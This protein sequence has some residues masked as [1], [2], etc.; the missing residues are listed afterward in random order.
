MAPAAASN[1]GLEAQLLQQQQQ[2]QLLQQQLWQQQQ[3]QQQH[4][5]QQQQSIQS[6]AQFASSSSPLLLDPF[7]MAQLGL[8]GA[9]GLGGG[10]TLQD[11]LLLATLQQMEEIQQLALM[12]SQASRQSGLQQ[13]AAGLYGGLVDGQLLGL[14]PGANH[15]S[16]LGA[17]P[18]DVLFNVGKPPSRSDTNGRLGSK[19]T[20][21][22]KPAS[23]RS[24]SHHPAPD[25]R[26]H[27]RETISFVMP[28]VGDLD[29]FSWYYSQHIFNSLNAMIHNTHRVQFN[30][31]EAHN[32]QHNPYAAEM[33]WIRPS[34]YAVTATLPESPLR[35]TLVADP[36]PSYTPGQPEPRGNS[37]YIVPLDYI[38]KNFN[39]SHP[40]I[41]RVLAFRQRPVVQHLLAEAQRVA[42]DGT[43][44]TT[45]RAA[46]R[47]PRPPVL[48]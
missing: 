46:P 1:P 32:D 9:E 39:T 20:V 15:E 44:P 17:A 37:S 26:A 23:G 14:A 13:P 25:S 2:Q 29:C 45:A 35:R 3:Q 38:H 27:H 7:L 12:Q 22:K 5:Q 19:F 34:C 47:G 41:A 43:G 8:G 30:A 48:L 21:I 10:L 24:S 4:Q 31:I 42:P 11:Q 33:W 18:N 6:M 36:N 16:I 28:Y 40:I